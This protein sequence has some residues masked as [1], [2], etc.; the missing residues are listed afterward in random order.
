MTP[1][2]CGLPGRG[3][4]AGLESVP[5]DRAC[6]RAGPSEFPG[7]TCREAPAGDGGDRGRASSGCRAVRARAFARTLGRGSYWAPVPVL[8]PAGPC[9]LLSALT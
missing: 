6:H 5:G 9:V 4:G 1:W 8:N 2:P 7:A 3:R